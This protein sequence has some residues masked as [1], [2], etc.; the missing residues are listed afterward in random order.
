MNLLNRI[1]A[2]HLLLG[3]VAMMST[4]PAALAQSAA[5][6]GPSLAGQVANIPGASLPLVYHKGPVMTGSVPVYLIWYGAWSSTQ[7]AIITNFINNL[8]GSAW[9][10]I[11]KAYP[12]GMGVGF[13]AELMVP[14][15]VDT[16]IA[17]TLTDAEVQALVANNLKSSA[18]PLNADAIYLVLTAS[19]VNQVPRASIHTQNGFC[20]AYCGWHSRF[21]YTNAKVSTDIK[22]AW[23]GNPAKCPTNC[24]PVQNEQASPN[25]DVGVDAAVNTI[26]REI[27]EAVTDPDS[28]AWY[29]SSGNEI[30]DKC[31]WTFGSVTTVNNKPV[32]YSYNIV[33]NGT[34]YM[35][36]QLW[37]NSGGVCAMQ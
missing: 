32:S 35:I 8:S 26:A 34:K 1:H 28:N 16:R 25:G 4:V 23:V 21:T 31:A 27:S 7:Q 14:A 22:Y 12:N 10:D 6:R 9:L 13:G 11:T 3:A 2:A 15:Q 29:D 36:Q 20:A 19:N 30:A 18:L 24:A 33:L 17:T 5:A 37:K